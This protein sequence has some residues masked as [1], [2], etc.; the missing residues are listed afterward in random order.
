MGDTAIEIR[1]LEK[2][3][4]G[5][6]ILRDINFS[7]TPG[8]TAVVLGKSGTGKSVLLKC[9]VLLL[10]PDAGSINVFGSDVLSLD[11]KGLRELRTKVGFIFQNGALYDSMTVRENLEFA[12]VRHFRLSRAEINEK[13]HDA[14][15][16]V[17][18]AGA[19]DK[20]PS[21]L[22]G[23]MQKR[24]ALARTLILN[25]KVMLWDEPT[26]GLD[27]ASSREISGLISRMQ[28]EFGATSVVVT[29]DMP[30]ARAVS[31]RIFVL[32]DGTFAEQGTYEQLE[33]SKDEFVCSFFH[34]N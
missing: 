11:D 8:E 17:D 6:A 10:Y 18:L 25:P 1:N 5:T 2:S 7:V 33:N 22:S 3:F 4:N 12:L 30:C 27:P 14:L 20:M 13:V 9:I 19:V 23:G 26:T 32:K 21:E 24:A 16:S 29:H 31:D 15:E 28:K 34:S